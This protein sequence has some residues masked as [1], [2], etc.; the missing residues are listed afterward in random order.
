M[1]DSRLIE[2]HT[3]GSRIT[4]RVTSMALAV[5]GAAAP[6]V[7]VSEPWFNGNDRN[8]VGECRSVVP[9]YA[10][11][12]DAFSRSNSTIPKTVTIAANDP[13][14]SDYDDYGFFELRFHATPLFADPT[15]ESNLQ[16]RMSD[17]ERWIFDHLVQHLAEVSRREY[18]RVDRFTVELFD[19]P[20]DGSREY[21]LTLHVPLTAHEAMKFWNR[22]G[23]FVML[24]ANELG[25]IERSILSERVGIGISWDE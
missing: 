17:R 7:G 11:G 8:Q 2:N 4:A 10:S 6:S 20:E 22:V 12:S 3:A 18:V 9:S 24:W 5:V 1:A 14:L 21:F 23:R 19:D 13:A 16:V 25:S 15:F